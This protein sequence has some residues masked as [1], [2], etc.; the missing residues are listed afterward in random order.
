MIR[1][2]F[3]VTIYFVLV[4][5]SCVMIT[6]LL[7]TISQSNVTVFGEAMEFVVFSTCWHIGIVLN[8]D[9]FPLNYLPFVVS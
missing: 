8:V 6:M 5:L 4:P 9:S 7:Y 2:V 3:Q 1:L